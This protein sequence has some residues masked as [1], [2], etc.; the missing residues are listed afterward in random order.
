MLRVIALTA[1]VA[2]PSIT[3]QAA[4]TT[5]TLACEGTVTVYEYPRTTTV[6]NLKPEPYSTGM[7]VDLTARTVQTFG[8]E[9]PF[10]MTNINAA[11]I[12]FSHSEKQ[13]AVLGSM[14]RVTGDM[15]A[16]ITH[17]LDMQRRDISNEQHYALKCKPTQRM[18]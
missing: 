11:T 14:D 6:E 17:W 8:S 3:T 13:M 18:F 10:K 2:G 12:V 5:L 1:M 9:Y 7:I 4:D 15:E 16:T